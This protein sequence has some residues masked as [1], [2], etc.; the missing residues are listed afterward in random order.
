MLCNA[1]NLISR[2]DC[3]A[4]IAAAAVPADAAALAMPLAIAVAAI[5]ATLLTRHF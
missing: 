3:L 2:R 5:V 1:A 4:D